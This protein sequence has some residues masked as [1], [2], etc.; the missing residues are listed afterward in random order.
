MNEAIVSNDLKSIEVYVNH[1]ICP[2]AEMIFYFP[3]VMSLQSG[4]V[5]RDD[6]QFFEELIL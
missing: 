1:F 3:L 6:H 2:N 5:Q 4:T